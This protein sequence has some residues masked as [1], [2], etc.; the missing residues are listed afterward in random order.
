M[1]IQQETTELDEKLLQKHSIN[2]NDNELGKEISQSNTLEV[3]PEQSPVTVTVTVKDGDVGVVRDEIVTADVAGVDETVAADVAGGED[4]DTNCSPV[5]ESETETVKMEVDADVSKHGEN[6]K[7][8][9]G[10]EAGVNEELVNEDGIVADEEEAVGDNEEKNVGVTENDDDDDEEE[11]ME[12]SSDTDEED[13]T[14]EEKLPVKRRRRR[15][16]KRKRGGKSIQVT[17]KSTVGR[18]KKIEEEDVCFI[19]F[20]GGD[21]VLCDK[22]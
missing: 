20:D 22:K 1:E 14:D 18:G 17:P 21:L 11:L 10:D 19:C 4:S 8:E 12:K 7:I 9:Q 15:G 2:I 13:T 5:I 3:K 16:R 6:I